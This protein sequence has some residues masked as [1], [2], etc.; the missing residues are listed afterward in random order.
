[1]SSTRTLPCTSWD[2][3]I[4]FREQCG[5]TWMRV[6]YED[7]SGKATT[8][9]QEVPKACHGGA[10]LG[11]GIS[12]FKPSL[13]QRTV[14]KYTVSAPAHLW[15][16]VLSPSIPL[17]DSASHCRN[18]ASAG[19]RSFLLCSAGRQEFM[20]IVRFFGQDLST[21]YDSRLKNELDMGQYWSLK[22]SALQPVG[23]RAQTHT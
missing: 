22:Q 19:P 15:Q 4:T 20:C 17:E 7:P 21:L 1:M 8:A 13:L 9:S 11:T 18:L 12:H 6:R 23:L 2:W 5:A 14:I 10:R 3:Y 16:H